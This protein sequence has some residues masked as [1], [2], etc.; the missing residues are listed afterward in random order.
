MFGGRTDRPVARVAKYGIGYTQ[1]GGTP[2]SLK[3]MMEKVESAWREAGRQGKPEIRALAYFAIGEDAAA[4]GE[5]NITAYY[6]EFGPR[7][8]PRVI[9]SASEARERVEAYKAVGCDELILFMTAPAVDQCERLAE[10]V[11]QA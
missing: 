11:L 1:G 5:A 6:G 3:M 4:E 10:A 9:K 7:V 8:W 2:E